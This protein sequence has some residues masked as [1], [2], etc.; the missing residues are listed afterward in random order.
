MYNA[1]SNESRDFGKLLEKQ[2]SSALQVV[3]K[4]PDV[5]LCSDGNTAENQRASSGHSGLI[6]VYFENPIIS[7][8][9][10]DRI[11][12]RLDRDI[13]QHIYHPSDQ[14]VPILR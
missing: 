6:Q 9:L 11:V 13:V 10:A 1:V 8:T 2:S 14:D 7:E 12:R 5:E 4:L 3:E